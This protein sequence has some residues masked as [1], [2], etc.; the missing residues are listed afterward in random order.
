[1]IIA[2]P[3][4]LFT[5]FAL[6]GV[7]AGLGWHLYRAQEGQAA[8]AFWTAAFAALALSAVLGGIYHGFAPTLTE[9]ARQFLW[10]ATVLAVGVATFG[11]VAGSSIGTT[12]GTLRKLILA[13]AVSILVV[14]SG[15]IIWHDSYVYVIANAAIAMLLVGAMHGLTALRDADRASRWMLG[16]VVVS[17][18]AAGVQAGGY[19]LHR[20]FNHNDLYHVIQIAATSLLY[21]GARQLRDRCSPERIQ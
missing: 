4:T 18:I 12:T 20:N 16:G 19:T 5:D 9:G 1:M 15:W 2:E 8:R 21:I 6:A 17:V 11:M 13:V 3:M 10:K 7:T 14:Y